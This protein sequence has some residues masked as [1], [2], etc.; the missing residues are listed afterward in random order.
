VHGD[1]GRRHVLDSL[2]P[3]QTPLIQAWSEET[4]DRLEPHRG[5]PFSDGDS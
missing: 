5:E 4:L 3:E 1:N 2:G